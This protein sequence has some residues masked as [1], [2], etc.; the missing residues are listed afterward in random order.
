MLNF[1]MRATSAS[2]LCAG[3]L[4]ASLFVVGPIHGDVNKLVLLATTTST[5]N[6]GLLDFILPVMEK[7]TG[8]KIRTISAGTGKALK[9]GEAGDVDVLLVHAK[10]SEQ[11][12]I[13]SQFG[14]DRRLIM[15]NEF[16][17]VGAKSDPGDL[18]TL[19]S[20]SA[21]F[22]SIASQGE[23]FI[24]RGDESGTHKK[25]LSIWN[26]VGIVPDGAW[27][28]QVGQGMGKT[29][30]ISDQLSG[31]TLTDRGTWIFSSDRLLM[32][33]IYQGDQRLHN[34][35][36]VIAVN[37]ARHDVNYVGA[38]AVGDWLVSAKGQSLINAYRIDGEQLFY[39]NAE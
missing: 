7:D 27:Y 19:S 39:A 22:K 31:Y 34:Q 23:V 8:Y 25:E 11:A 16:V 30:Q 3:L 21:V 28:R 10:E 4:M 33:I 35:Y 24:S 37:P 32:K 14:V 26:S 2:R 13:D 29:L 15:F 20:L 38:T 6:S 9:M 1:S 17:V 5:E 18:G 36:S 12:F